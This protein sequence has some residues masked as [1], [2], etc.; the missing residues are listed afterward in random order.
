[1]VVTCLAACTLHGTKLN[2]ELDFS[3]VPSV[4]EFQ[5]RAEVVFGHES[6]ARRPPDVPVAPF[7][8][9]RMQVYNDGAETWEDLVSPSQLVD[10]C[11]VYLFQRETPWHREVQSKIP[12]AVKPHLRPVG[13]PSP[14][15]P[16]QQPIP[17]P[18]P[19]LQPPPVH[20]S[21][22]APAAP[23]SSYPS[24]QARAAPVMP[25][26]PPPAPVPPPAPAYYSPAPHQ[27]GRPAPRGP[28]VDGVCSFD[29]K[30]R[31]VFADFGSPR[32]AVDVAAWSA[33]FSKFGIALADVTVRD[34]F[35]HADA[36]GDGVLSFAEFHRFAE[37]YPTLL[38][39]LFYRGREHWSMER[40]QKAIDEARRTAAVLV[41]REQQASLVHGQAEENV[42]M[43][44][45]RVRDQSAEVAAA[46]R[47]EADALAVLESASLETQRAR[48]DAA[49]AR[50][51]L[52]RAQE[53][54]RQ[55][56]MDHT[57]AVRAVEQGQATVRTAD[58]R[59]AALEERLA[60][61]ERMLEEQ[62]DSVDAARREAAGVRADLAAV[63]AQEQIAAATAQEAEAGVRSM[64]EVVQ[65]VDEHAAAGRR[66]CAPAKTHAP[67]SAV[68]GRERECGQVV[69]QA[70]DEVARQAAKRDAEAQELRALEEKEGHARAL[71]AEA[72][73]VAATQ[74]D[75]VQALEVELADH[76]S[77]RRQAEE[78][79]RVLLEQEVR[80][81]AQRLALERE[82]ARLRDDSR[83]FHCFTGRVGNPAL[84]SA[85]VLPSPCAGSVGAEEIRMVMA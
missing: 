84:A 3:T 14:H 30:A 8:V 75:R 39:C 4:L 26:Q 52:Q 48:Q 71:R 61:I 18:Q 15:R 85:G 34:L 42:R 13:Q 81:R 79:E 76:E 56:K 33:G 68:E 59:L 1:M 43:Q 10:F 50:P 82:E 41:D 24:P 65:Q 20:H 29:E 57:D 46:E 54:D 66:S 25:L 69:E 44:E 49:A 27:Y 55:K 47:R 58:G 63:E 83:D 2:Y 36:N 5:S 38:D 23:P 17:L 12:P 21:V 70:R 35:Q 78:K 73:R 9:H 62:R 72:G 37:L 74:Q 77:K 22:V 32:S 16:Q 53:N 45:A 60:E 40:Q 67:F 31:S 6:A 11:Q 80:L 64:L 28:S 51:D 7:C 19:A